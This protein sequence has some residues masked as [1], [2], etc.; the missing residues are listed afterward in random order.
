MR[1]S[2]LRLTGA[3]IA[4]AASTSCA[5]SEED[6][7]ATERMT[8]ELPSVEP[9]STLYA[10][11]QALNT[12]LRHRAA[13][14]VERF[15]AK[16]SVGSEFLVPITPDGAE[17]RLVIA[18][19]PRR[20]VF[21]AFQID[22]G[23]AQSPAAPGKKIAACRAEF[24]PAALP[25][26]SDLGTLETFYSVLPDFASCTPGKQ[27]L[28]SQQLRLREKG[29]PAGYAVFR[30]GDEAAAVEQKDDSG[31]LDP[32]A[33]LRTLLGKTERVAQVLIFPGESWRKGYVRTAS[34]REFLYVF[35]GFNPMDQTA[36]CFV[37]NISWPEF[38]DGRMPESRNSDRGFCQEAFTAQRWAAH[39]RW[40]KRLKENPPRI[41]IAPLPEIG[42]KPTER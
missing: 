9:G 3:A 24:D 16:A 42:A 25:R 33:A 31:R 12:Q 30:Q 19:S 14:E 28:P 13:A 32:G 8:L 1:D 21:Y 17:R 29:D 10:N 18:V 26:G 15:G 6:A 36:V 41:M 11:F 4:L 35:N 22:K 27:V 20:A 40:E 37:E 23:A 7:V 2:F 38:V 5:A 34:G 39:Q